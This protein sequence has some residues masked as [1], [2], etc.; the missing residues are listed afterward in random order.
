M[1]KNRHLCSL[2]T[3]DS[4]GLPRLAPNVKWYRKLA[5]NVWKLFLVNSNHF[6][7]KRLFRN[8]S[9]ILAEKRRHANSPYFLVIHPLSLLYSILEVMFFVMW[10]YA[11]VCE[12]MLMMDFH[13]IHLGFELVHYNIVIPSRVIL[14]ALLFNAGYIDNKSKE[15]VIQPRIIIC[16]YLKTYFFFDFLTTYWLFLIVKLMIRN[17]IL[18]GSQIFIFRCEEG[19][20][21]VC[22]SAC[23]V[24][25]YTMLNFMEN[26]LS[27]LGLG[28]ITRFVLLCLVKTFLYIHIF[29]CLVFFVP[30]LIYA[31]KFPPE[32]WLSHAKTE[33]FTSFFQ[34]YFECFLVASSYF[35]GVSERHAITLFSEQICMV[36]ISFVGR[37]YTLFLLADVLNMLGIAGVS[38]SKYERQMSVLHQYM[39]AKN[40]P[41]G[42]RRRMLKYFE[43]KHQ[44]RFFKENEIIDSL[45]ETLRTELFLFAANKLIRKV[46]VFRKLPTST[47][48]AI[49]A[50]M[51]SEIYSP[52]D[53]IV[54]CGAELNDLF[55]I[56]SGTV[57]VVNKRGV[58]LCHL[59]D[60]ED[61]ATSSF[62]MQ[63]QLYA[64]TAVETT[65]V[66]FMDKNEFLKFL[67]PHP[68]VKAEFYRSYQEKLAKLKV[69]E[70]TATADSIDL[71]SELQKG[72]ILEKLTRR[73]RVK[74][75]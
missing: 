3:I 28:K 74:A 72:H 61:F 49:I 69:L 42:L 45:S 34:L 31:N 20:E 39:A 48:G 59:E 4:N 30:Y 16:R 9:S 73:P 13:N 57:A 22:L 2:T 10:M 24:R 33:Q 50:M 68:E 70:N 35:F 60:G 51:K 23:C 17:K 5:R 14:V 7:C 52:G 56:S 32:S 19:S 11:F 71:M 47:L 66:F 54:K 44:G 55:F 63:R 38:E 58:E 75:N 29:A 62:I 6:M 18:V 26:T 67:E 37:L 8:K 36:L 43:F 64:V 1:K 53:V 40:L 12:S 65:E 25:I 15:I 46:D 21:I 27:N 41:E